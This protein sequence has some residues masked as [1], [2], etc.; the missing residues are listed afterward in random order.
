MIDNVLQG[1]C[2]MVLGVSHHGLEQKKV[3]EPL[4]ANSY[5]TPIRLCGY[6]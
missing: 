2:D 6:R 5:S 3:Q 1:W 4:I